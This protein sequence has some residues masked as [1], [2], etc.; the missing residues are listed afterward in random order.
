[1]DLFGQNLNFASQRRV[2]F[3]FLFLLGEV[4]SGLG[5]PKRR[6]PTPA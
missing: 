5:L 6:S 3:E 1:V 4:M 2:G